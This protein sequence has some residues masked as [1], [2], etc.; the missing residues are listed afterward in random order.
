M[1]LPAIAAYV[2]RT[3]RPITV[4]YGAHEVDGKDLP[5]NGYVYRFA[6]FAPGSEPSWDSSAE[7][8]AYRFCYEMVVFAGVR[9]YAVS[10]VKAYDPDWTARDI[11]TV[12]IKTDFIGVAPHWTR[13]PLTSRE[14]TLALGLSN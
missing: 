10:C 7:S 11:A 8:L 2:R 14:I 13:A 5:E 12:A 9:A 6:T 3:L 4:R 1:D